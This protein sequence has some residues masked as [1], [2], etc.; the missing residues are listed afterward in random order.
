ME[1]VIILLLMFLGLS[2]FWLELFV[3]QGTTWAAICGALCVG[4]S[5]WFAF[6]ELGFFVGILVLICIFLLFSF[7]MWLTLR[8][9]LFERFIRH[10]QS[11]AKSKQN[12]H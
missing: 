1:I 5:M 11:R 9:R 10:R 4:G 3:F 7:L 2:L 6:R 8:M 12:K